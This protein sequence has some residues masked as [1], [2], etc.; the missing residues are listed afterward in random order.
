MSGFI[1]SGS[2][3]ESIVDSCD[4]KVAIWSSLLPTCKKDPLRPDGKVDEVMYEQ[5]FRTILRQ[6]QELTMH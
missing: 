5:P 1:E 4:T 3:V 6:V 2:F